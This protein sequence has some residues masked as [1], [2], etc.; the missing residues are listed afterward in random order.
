M[1]EFSRHFGGIFCNFNGVRLFS[2]LGNTG[3]IVFIA[4]PQARP[5]PAGQGGES[6]FFWGGWGF[7]DWGFDDQIPTPPSGN[8]C[9]SHVAPHP[10]QVEMGKASYLQ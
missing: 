2:I 6:R 8:V 5:L 3:G 1:D 4:R 7:G 9:E 10:H